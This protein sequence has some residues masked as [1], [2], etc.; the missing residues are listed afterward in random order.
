MEKV[1][2]MQFQKE[3]E[4]TP[5]KNIILIMLGKTVQLHLLINKMFQC[6]V[7]CIQNHLELIKTKLGPSVIKEK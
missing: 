4:D 6:S 5:L 7:L 1:W 3:Q 2:I